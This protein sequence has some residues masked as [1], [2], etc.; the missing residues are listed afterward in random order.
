M[1]AEDIERQ[2][3]NVHRMRLMGA[4]VVPVTAGDRTLKD[5]VNEALR[6]WAASFEDTHYLLGTA[7][8]PHPF[9]LMVRQFQRV[10]G[11]EARAD[12]C[13]G[14][15]RQPRD[16]LRQLLQPSVVGVAAVPDRRIRPE[17]QLEPARLRRRRGGGRLAFGSRKPGA[18]SR[19]RGAGSRGC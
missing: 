14:V 5:A 8:G 1:G 13:R 11:R 16:R 2:A 6:D 3:L 4:T 17:N 10:I 12:P 19:I 15:P 7:A 9:P 18:G